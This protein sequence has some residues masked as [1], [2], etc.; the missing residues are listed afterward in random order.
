M[1]LAHRLEFAALCSALLP[2]LPGCERGQEAAPLT[3]CAAAS[4]AEVLAEAADSFTAETKASVRLRCASSGILARQIEAGAPGDVFC[5]ANQQWMDYLRG[6]GLLMQGT[7]RP[8]WGNRLAVV[9]PAGSTQ[10]LS[11]PADLVLVKRLAIGNPE[12]VPAGLYARQALLRLGLWESLVPRILAAG[13]ARMAL[14]LVERGEADAG[15][16]YVTDARGSDKARI[17]FQLPEESHDPIIYPGAVLRDCRSPELAEA[18]LE[19]LRSPAVQ[20]VFRRYGFEV[21]EP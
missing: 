8:L 21:V 17:A 14:A 1:R 13:D 3:V 2:A 15:V 9:T 6:R 4:L 19:H 5:P 12:S 16:V 10:R 11:V 20:A 7:V 18:F